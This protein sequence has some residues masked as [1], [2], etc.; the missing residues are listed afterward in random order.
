MGREDQELIKIFNNIEEN[1]LE[2]KN[3]LSTRSV[4][5]VLNEYTDIDTLKFLAI[6]EKYI[7][8]FD[9]LKMIKN[10]SLLKKLDSK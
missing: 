1:L 3:I 9:S 6:I 8:N 10:K 2:V 7:E 4:V 5:K